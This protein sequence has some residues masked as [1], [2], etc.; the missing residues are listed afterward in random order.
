MKHLGNF[1]VLSTGRMDCIQFPKNKNKFDLR[2]P[3]K[4]VKIETDLSPRQRAEGKE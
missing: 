4:N 1:T 3:K 2:N